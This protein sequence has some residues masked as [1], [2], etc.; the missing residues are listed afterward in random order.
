M[1]A[2]AY[3]HRQNKK[4]DKTAEVLLAVIME[5]EGTRVISRKQ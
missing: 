5:A 2:E 1:A 4:N 3:N